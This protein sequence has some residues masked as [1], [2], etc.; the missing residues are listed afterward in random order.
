MFSFAQFPNMYLLLTSILV[1]LDFYIF[2][3]F[4]AKTT[5]SFLPIKIIHLGYKS[6]LHQTPHLYL[7]WVFLDPKCMT[8][9]LKSFQC[10]C[11]QLRYNVRKIMPI[12]IE[13]WN[14]ASKIRRYPIETKLPDQ[15]VVLTKKKKKG[16][17]FAFPFPN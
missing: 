16:K 15:R 10:F 8:C 12:K 2:E 13:E 9:F 3:G 4:D 17:L 14:K 11:S 6:F 1:N 7:F 5:S